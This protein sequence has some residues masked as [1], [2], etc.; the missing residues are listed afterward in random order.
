M[1]EKD[2]ISRCAVVSVEMPFLTIFYM[3][4]Q[5]GASFLVMCATAFRVRRLRDDA[6]VERGTICDDLQPPT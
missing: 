2:P 3:P 6:V 4:C 1:R 5:G